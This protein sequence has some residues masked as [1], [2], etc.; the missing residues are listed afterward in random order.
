M[1]VAPALK[2]TVCPGATVW[3]IGLTVITGAVDTG[4]T[5]SVAGA[6]AADPE[7]LVKTASYSLPF[8]PAAAVKLYVGDVAPAMGLK[9][10]PLFVLTS[11]W[12]VGLPVAAAVKVAVCPATTL[13]LVGSTVTTGAVAPGATTL[14][15]SSPAPSSPSLT[16]KAVRGPSCVGLVEKVTVSDV[17]L[18]AVTVPTASLK[19]TL[20]LAG[21]ASKPV[22]SITTV[23]AV[24]GRLAVLGVTTGPDAGVGVG[25]GAGEGVG[26]G[27]G[28]GAGA[29]VGVGVGVGAGV[30]VGVAVIET[31]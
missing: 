19:K 24:D 14:A 28:V 31:L 23:E 16:T 20:S 18:A 6:L 1:P 17:A 7:L 5:V 12:T 10:A 13:T 29:G 11:H 25:V 8:W 9:P 30:E 15:T 2:A 4:E 26:V 3:L 27:V 21:V 22:P